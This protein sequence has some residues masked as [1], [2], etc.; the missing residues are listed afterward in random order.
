[1]PRTDVVKTIPAGDTEKEVTVNV[2]GDPGDEQN[3]TLFVNLT[4]I[5]NA[6]GVDVQ[7]LGT[8]NDDDPGPEFSVDSQTGTAEGAAATTHDLTFTVTKSGVTLQTTTVTYTT[9]NLNAFAPGDYVSE[10]AVLTFAPADTTKT[11]TI[12]VNG[13]ASPE[14]D[15]TFAVNLSAPT[16]GASVNDSDTPDGLGGIVND[17]GDP[18]ELSIDNVTTAEGQSSTTNF[19]FTVTLDAA[20]DQAVTVDVDSTLGSAEADDLVTVDE[21][22]TI[23]A[24]STTVPVNATVNGD[25]T[26]ETNETFNLTLSAPI[27]AVIGDGDTPHG[28]GTISN[29]DTQPTLSVDDVIHDEG[30]TSVTNYE[31]TI[32]ASNK[33]EIGP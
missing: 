25:T 11:F 9:A 16:G 22:V 21:T 5:T 33:T 13:D 18:R 15:E 20:L 23:P 28:L 27:N 2:V 14:P 19:G 12:T 6:T 1:M 32:T 30:D 3:E 26:F 29:D 10:T 8:I 24:G 4:A 7:G 17:D 31:F